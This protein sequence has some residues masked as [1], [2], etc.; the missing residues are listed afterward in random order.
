MSFCLWVNSALMVA[1]LVRDGDSVNKEDT[2]GMGNMNQVMYQCSYIFLGLTY[3]L[4]NFLDIILLWSYFRLDQK[5]SE[6]MKN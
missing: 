2:M 3:A 6:R 1:L 4:G 5:L